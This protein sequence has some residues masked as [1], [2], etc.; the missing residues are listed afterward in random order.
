M[1]YFSNSS[2]SYNISTSSESENEIKSNI[3]YNTVKL[4]VNKDHIPF[5]TS[6]A[7]SLSRQTSNNSLRYFKRL[8]RNSNLYQSETQLKNKY[9]A[10]P[11]FLKS[12]KAN[13]NLPDSKN[14]PNYKRQKTNIKNKNIARSNSIDLNK[15]FV[16]AFESS[17]SSDFPDIK[18]LK[19][20]SKNKE[21]SSSPDSKESK[22]NKSYSSL[23]NKKRPTVKNSTNNNKNKQFELLTSSNSP[24]FSREKIDFSN[25][26]NTSNN[27]LNFD[28]LVSDCSLSDVFFIRKNDR[29]SKSYSTLN[30]DNS[31]LRMK[32]LSPKPLPLNISLGINDEPVS[33]KLKNVTINISNLFNDVNAEN[34]QNQIINENE[35][36]GQE[37]ILPL[38]INLRKYSDELL[39]ENPSN[40]TIN[41]S[42]LM[43]EDTENEPNQI[44]KNDIETDYQEYVLSNEYSK[45]N[46]S[47]LS[48]VTIYVPALINKD[49]ENETNP[50]V[51]T[52]RTD[53]QKC[54]LSN[55]QS[56]VNESKL[57]SDEII[58]KNKPKP[59]SN[60]FKSVEE[61]S[62]HCCSHKCPCVLKNNIKNTK[63]IN[64]EL[65]NKNNKKQYKSKRLQKKP[66]ANTCSMDVL[67]IKKKIDMK[68]IRNHC[69][70]NKT[71]DIGLEYDTN[72]DNYMVEL[73]NGAL[74]PAFLS[75]L[76]PKYVKKICACGITIT[77]IPSSWSESFHNILHQNI[78]KLRFKGNIPENDIIHFKQ[79][80]LLYKILIL[81]MN[82]YND[83][84]IVNSIKNVDDFVNLEYGI[85]KTNTKSYEHLTYLAI[86]PNYKVIGYLQ[87]QLIQRAYT[88]TSDEYAPSEITIPAKFGISKIWV[89]IK[90]RN[91]NVDINLLETFCKKENFQKK[92]LAFSLAGCQGIQFIQEFTG[93]KNILI[94]SENL[95]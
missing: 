45:V 16:N 92:H 62:K 21:F 14:L 19:F 9:S 43:N 3:N 12:S 61:T 84:N 1:N 72:K 24:E 89:L 64:S 17:S 46:K 37:R 90:Y 22:P 83:E 33:Q 60:F 48:N 58:I 75:T 53:N 44:I 13:Y 5:R 15:E 49:T 95:A 40:D 81:H 52:I 31:F 77:E 8:K 35:K 18:Y 78:H 91:K 79:N 50:V 65:K 93:S 74:V 55:E 36:Y 4:N 38:N 20:I 51:N 80:G 30:T 23:K 32:S 88:F 29:N 34:K 56:K 66:L 73:P 42:G 7:S 63:H 70:T 27:E 85:S 26:P 94:Y 76:K 67:R 11:Y 59:T 39:P 82:N 71:E 25:M 86:L 47:K 57:F 87:V 69:S 68:K 41:I 2:I 6:L 10:T 28:G 54:I